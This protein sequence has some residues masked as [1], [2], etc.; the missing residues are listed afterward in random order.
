[1]ADMLTE[2]CKTKNIYIYRFLGIPG[3]FIYVFLRSLLFKNVCFA[4]YYVFKKA[5]SS[6]TN[7]ST[8]CS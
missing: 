6:Q 8:S 3:V 5:Q 7:M 1:M 2:I 4:Y